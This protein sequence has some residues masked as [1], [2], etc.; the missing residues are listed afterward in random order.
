MFLGRGGGCCG[1]T[2]R[3]GK[4]RAACK[5]RAYGIVILGLDTG[6]RADTPISKRDP[7]LFWSLS[8]G[9][10]DVVDIEMKRIERG[11]GS[12]TEDL[13]IIIHES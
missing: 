6:V 4:G 13:H 5:P 7:C 10:P 8:K 2:R 12:K 9:S 11:I 3:R 1:G